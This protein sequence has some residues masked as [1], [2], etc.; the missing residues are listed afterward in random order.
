MISAV[1]DLDRPS[2]MVPSPCFI[3]YFDADILSA[4]KIVTKLYLVVHDA[5]YFMF[6]DSLADKQKLKNL[7]II[8]IS[9]KMATSSNKCEGK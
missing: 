3:I 9:Y 2:H 5:P 4:W 6:A 7:S 8:Y 1:Y